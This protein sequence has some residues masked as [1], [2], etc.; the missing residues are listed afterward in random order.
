MPKKKIKKTLEELIHLPERSV[1][2]WFIL[3]IDPS[4][5]R[6][7]FATANYKD[8]QFGWQ[9]IGSI[10]PDSSQYP[11]WVR[12][13][14]MAVRLAQMI[15][16]EEVGL[17]EDNKGILVCMEQPTPGNDWLNVLNKVIQAE[18][19]SVM[20]MTVPV[21][22]LHVNAATLRSNF[23]LKRTGNNKD[24]NIRK[25]HE[26]ASA[27]LFPGIDSDSCDAILLA[28]YAGFVAELLATGD[29][30]NIPER[31]LLSLCDYSDVVKGK[32]TRERIVKKGLLH[33]PVYWSA[34]Q[35]TQYS[36]SIKDARIPSKRRLLKQTMVL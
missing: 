6:T 22:L 3:G 11:V 26:F 27:H 15:L 9:S 28:R 2:N 18:L 29:K 33:N 13:K 4:L 24:E 25:S 23:E 36:M 14:M 7:G 5:S 32:G 16:R 1:P 34:Y 21:Y 20:P 19:F 30:T 8:G 12:S 10:K 17:L 35:K 31:I